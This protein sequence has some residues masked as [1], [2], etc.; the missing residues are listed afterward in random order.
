MACNSLLLTITQFTSPQTFLEANL[1]SA[2]I[3]GAFHSITSLWLS[4][5]TRYFRISTWSSLCGGYLF[6]PFVRGADQFGLKNCHYFHWAESCWHCTS[7]TLWRNPILCEHNGKHV[8][9]LGKLPTW[10]HTT[11]GFK[12]LFSLDL[13]RHL[14]TDKRYSC[15]RNAL[16]SPS[17]GFVKW[18]PLFK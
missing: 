18:K 13:S 6:H 16:F 3:C 15:L 7:W 11:I 17:H 1:S 14:R 8:R 12:V 5:F 10:R 4:W 9:A 2:P